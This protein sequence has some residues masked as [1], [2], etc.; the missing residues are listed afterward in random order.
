MRK[1][2]PT[3]ER[4][5]LLRLRDGEHAAFTEIYN[6]YKRPLASNMLRMVKSAELTED[7]LQEL[8]TRLWDNRHSID[9][10]KNISSYLY[11]VGRNLVTD[12]FRRS[13]RDRNLAR[14]LYG[15]VKESYSHIEES[16]FRKENAA[17]LKGLLDNLSPQ[18]KLVFTLCKIEG[19]SY[20][21]VSVKLGISVDAVNDHIRK[22][23]KLLRSRIRPTDVVLLALASG[24]Y[25]H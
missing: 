23:N 10:E 4:E 25:L 14:Q 7:L 2:T 21:E 15:L 16:I 24:L 13:M 12:V 20:K 6:T 5:L 17:L 18:R 22:A 8:F 11:R 1:D 3:D 19:M 9:T